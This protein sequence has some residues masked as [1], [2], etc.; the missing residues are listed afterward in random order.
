[1]FEGLPETS[2]NAHR[3]DGNPDAASAWALRRVST[4]T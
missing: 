1:M 3:A 2:E 4:F